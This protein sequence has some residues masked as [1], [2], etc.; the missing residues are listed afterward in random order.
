MLKT[1]WG[2]NVPPQEAWKPSK[3][4]CVKRKLLVGFS[5]VLACIWTTILLLFFMQEAKSHS[6]VWL[7]GIDYRAGQLDFSLQFR[8]RVR[9]GPVLGQ[10][11]KL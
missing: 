10:S 7:Q 5:D 3:W 4:W 2:P 9:G 6:A 8:E 11:Y 1:E